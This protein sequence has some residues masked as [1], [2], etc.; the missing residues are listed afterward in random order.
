MGGADPGSAIVRPV[1]VH[2][3]VPVGVSARGV[4][5]VAAAAGY[6][7]GRRRRGGGAGARVDSREFR[8]VGRGQ[9]LKYP[10]VGGRDDFRG[11]GLEDGVH[12]ADLEVAAGEQVKQ[13]GVSG[14]VGGDEPAVD[15]LSAPFL[16]A[17][18]AGS[19]TRR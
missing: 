8:L 2:L 18:I 7:G 6:V 9:E 10:G 19:S 13:C 12:G 15:V 3:R 16:I 14:P 11:Q 1:H 4:A 17:Q 5:I